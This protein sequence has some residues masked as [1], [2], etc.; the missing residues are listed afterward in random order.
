VAEGYFT[1]AAGWALAQKLG[2]DMPITEQVYR[3]LHER[4]PLAEAMTALIERAHKDECRDRL[5][6]ALW[7]C[8]R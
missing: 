8:S 2:V 4:R 7:C 6:A 5:M 1:S 3:V